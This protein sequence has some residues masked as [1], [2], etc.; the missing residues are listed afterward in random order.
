MNCSDLQGLLSG[1][2][3]GE[4]LPAQAE[5][6]TLHLRE[7]SG[8]RRSVDDLRL[9]RTQLETLRYDGYQPQ[10]TARINRALPRRQAWL[11]LSRWGRF[12]AAVSLPAL[13]VLV[14]FLVLRA[15]GLTAPASGPYVY[16]V[17]GGWAVAT[18]S[19]TGEAIHLQAV[20][21]GAQVA[22]SFL[23][24]GD[25]LFQLKAD[26][27]R[28]VAR[29]DGLLLGPSPD[30]SVVWVARQVTP[31]SFAV[32]KV[33]VA[34]GTV[35]TGP[36]LAPGVVYRGIVSAD[37]QRLYLLASV[38]EE[39]FLKVVDPGNQQ[40]A[41]AHRLP[42][43]GP[44]ARILAHGDI[45]HVVDDG[46]VV[47][48]TLAPSGGLFVQEV[49]GL[50]RAVALAPGG[51]TL[52]AVLEDGDVALIDSRSL[53]ITRRV[54]G[55]GYQELLWPEPDRLVAIGQDGLDRFTY[56]GLRRIR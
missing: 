7:C 50:T 13:A 20:D 52:A 27:A 23:L 26:Q 35:A 43:V 51:S 1:Y 39:V 47:R 36:E 18:D 32:D 2:A 17:A 19:G 34:A 28:P 15:P 5:F 55:A 31:N 54:N 38:G 14:L 25:T 33:D 30:G 12:G 45:V 44:D 37:G 53:Q 29:T 48:L 16:R 46:L 11:A 22:G 10:L 9:T 40:R 42:L 6:V 21:P 56:P 4:L 49:P 8:C 41:S 24:A 3:A